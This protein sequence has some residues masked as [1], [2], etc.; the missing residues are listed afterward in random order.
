MKPVL[1]PLSPR[2]KSVW[3]RGVPLGA[4]S[5]RLLALWSVLLLIGFAVALTLIPDPSGSGTH[6]QL[7]LPPCTLKFLFEIPCPS[8][9]MT[10]SF[11]HFVRGQ[12]VASGRANPAGLLLAGLCLVQIPWCWISVFTGRFWLL[13]RPDWA[14]LAVLISVIGVSL[15]QWAIRLGGLV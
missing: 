5:R 3:Q 6:R 9:G 11:A 15:I 1:S 8:C 12:W 10:T 4:R 13:R 2:R 14:A 7:G